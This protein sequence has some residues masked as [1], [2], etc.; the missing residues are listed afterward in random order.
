VSGLCPDDHYAAML[1]EGLRLRGSGGCQVS[2]VGAPIYGR[3]LV[4]AAAPGCSG[5]SQTAVRCL[6][7]LRA[8]NTSSLGI[9]L[10]KE[11]LD[12]VAEA[13]ECRIHQ[14]CMELKPVLLQERL[15]A[16]IRLSI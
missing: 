16:P 15:H 4:G 8:G 7:H 12:A 14:V 2:A 3:D 1:K 6:C 9:S 13:E 11:R 10:S 5:A